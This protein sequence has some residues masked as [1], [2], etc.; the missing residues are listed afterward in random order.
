MGTKY[1]GVLAE[2]SKA[3]ASGAS[4]ATRAGSNPAD[5]SIV[6]CFC[7]LLLD[8]SVLCGLGRSWVVSDGHPVLSVVRPVPGWASGA[9]GTRWCPDGLFGHRQFPNSLPDSAGVRMARWLRVMSAVAPPGE[10]PT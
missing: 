6:F 1:S 9:A 8:C 7:F 5:V 3:L 4:G 2:W 10:K